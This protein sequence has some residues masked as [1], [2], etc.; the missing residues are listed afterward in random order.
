MEL[1]RIETQCRTGGRLVTV[2]ATLRRRASGA[3]QV[4]TRVPIDLRPARLCEDREWM[5]ENHDALF[6]ALIEAA[7]AYYQRRCARDE[8]AS[9]LRQGELPFELGDEAAG[10]EGGPAA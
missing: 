6:D 7:E 9:N 5:F 2:R 3:W 10:S 4:V 1:F 8:A